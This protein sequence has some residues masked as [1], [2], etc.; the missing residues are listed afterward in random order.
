MEA[1]ARLLQYGSNAD[2]L[3][4]RAS[5]AGAIF[6]R[7]LEPLSVILL[8][9]GI[10]S[11]V[12]GDRVGGAIIV[13]ILVLSIGLDTFQ[14]GRAV[15]AAEVLRRSVALKAEVKRNGAFVP[16]E[17]GTVVPGDVIRVRSGDIIPADALVLEATAFTTSEAALTGEPYPVEKRPGI[18]AARN[19]GEASNALF[20]GAVA[21][22]ARLWRWLL[23]RAAELC[24]AP[25][26]RRSARARRLRP[27]SA[28]C[29]RS[30]C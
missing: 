14:E 9:A 20:R 17:V 8:S 23:A 21:R 5:V 18:V 12:T 30:A 1:A 24:S 19:A 16:V 10:V 7:L 2:V 26:P 3:P 6:R 22:P 13:A 25:P 27:F 28:T 11:T 29:A 4:K 15:K